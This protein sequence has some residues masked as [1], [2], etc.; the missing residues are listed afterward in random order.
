MHRLA[1]DMAPARPAKTS[2]K[3][4]GIAEAACGTIGSVLVNDVTHCD[5]TSGDIAGCVDRLSTSSKLAVSLS[6]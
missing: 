2:I 6:K 3:V 5:H 1:V 4:F